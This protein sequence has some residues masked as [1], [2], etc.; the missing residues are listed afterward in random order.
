MRSLPVVFF[1]NVIPQFQFI[2]DNLINIILLLLAENIQHLCLAE[3]ND[4]E[5]SQAPICYS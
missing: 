4:I 5:I 1:A 3:V 2:D